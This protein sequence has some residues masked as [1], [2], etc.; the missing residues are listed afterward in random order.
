MTITA[1][2]RDC[3][4]SIA[5]EAA[6][7]I[8]KITDHCVSG[9]FN[10]L[11]KPLKKTLRVEATVCPCHTELCNAGNIT[12]GRPDSSRTTQSTDTTSLFSKISHRAIQLNSTRN[13]PGGNQLILGLSVGLG[14]GI[15]LI[16]VIIIVVVCCR[17]RKRRR[18]TSGDDNDACDDSCAAPME[19]NDG[20]DDDACI[21]AVA[22]TNNS[23]NKYK[24]VA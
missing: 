17:R 15:L 13:P 3:N 7:K 22:E 19:L 9:V 16:T 4:S 14:C 2:L 12:L 20:D 8:P 18:P 23:A 5:V 1:W 11:Y 21:L 6:G 10:Y 24:P